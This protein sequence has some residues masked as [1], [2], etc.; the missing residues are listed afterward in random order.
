MYCT[1]SDV[2]QFFFSIRSLL[3]F[4]KFYPVTEILRVANVIRGCISGSWEKPRH[5]SGEERMDK[6]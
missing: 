6:I 3:L 2:E 1:A 5:P 4:L